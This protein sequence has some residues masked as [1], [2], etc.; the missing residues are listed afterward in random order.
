MQF[1]FT[2]TPL[3]EKT[4]HSN[5]KIIAIISNRLVKLK[6]T[7]MFKYSIWHYVGIVNDFNYALFVGFIKRVCLCFSTIRKYQNSFFFVGCQSLQFAQRALLILVSVQ[8]VVVSRFVL[9]FSALYSLQT[10]PRSF[11]F[12]FQ[13]FYNDVFSS[14]GFNAFS[15]PSYI[16]QSST[17]MNGCG[18]Q[19]QLIRRILIFLGY[20]NL[21]SNINNQITSRF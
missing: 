6:I 11:Y 15:L 10:M 13:T 16:H 21:I 14:L 12:S 1:F 7:L 4:Y 8:L 17:N 19:L 9:L 5:F 3:I 18:V 2:N 20:F